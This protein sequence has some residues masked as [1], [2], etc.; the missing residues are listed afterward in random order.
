LIPSKNVISGK[1][2]GND[3]KVLEELKKCLPVQYSDGYRAIEVDGDH[4]EK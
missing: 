4:V 1:H 2:F 3:D